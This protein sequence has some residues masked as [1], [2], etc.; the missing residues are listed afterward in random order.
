MRQFYRAIA[1]VAVIGASA[2]TRLVPRASMTH[3]DFF[4]PLRS[5]AY[6]Y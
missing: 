4:A 2:D 5:T 3:S 1:V 6:R